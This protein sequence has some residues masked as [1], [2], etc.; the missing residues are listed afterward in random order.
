MRLVN[1]KVM[2]FSFWHHYL[3]VKQIWKWF[4]QWHSVSISWTWKIEWILF[5][6][7]SQR[8]SSTKK[9]KEYPSMMHH[10]T[11]LIIYSK[12]IHS[13]TIFKRHFRFL[14][15]SAILGTVGMLLL[16]TS[17]NQ[18][19]TSTSG[20]YLNSLEAIQVGL[21]LWWTVVYKESTFQSVQFAI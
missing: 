2:S 15:W 10:S 18:H 16:K 12:V 20:K 14:F 8:R 4:K 9:K 1:S 11:R 6:N 5:S 7:D 19:L 13:K 3:K 17:I 21:R